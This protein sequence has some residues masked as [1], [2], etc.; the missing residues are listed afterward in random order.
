VRVSP[1]CTRFIV[2]LVGAGYRDSEFVQWRWLSQGIQ[3]LIEAS[4]ADKYTAGSNT[5]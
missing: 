4:A 2:W 1:I 3:G 5:Y